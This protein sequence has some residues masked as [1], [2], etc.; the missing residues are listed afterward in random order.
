[1]LHV[2]MLLTLLVTTGTQELAEGTVPG[3]LDRP[4]G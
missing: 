2:W 3:R 4:A 1:M